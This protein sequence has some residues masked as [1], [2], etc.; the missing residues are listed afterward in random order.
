[1]VDGLGGAPD[2][3]AWGH[4]PAGWERGPADVDIW[5]ADVERHALAIGRLE[6]LLADAEWERVARYH[7]DRDRRRF[8]VVRGLLRALLGRYLGQPP[9]SLRIHYGPH[10][11][12]ELAPTS[13]TI[14]PLFDPRDAPRFDL[15]FNVSHSHGRALFAFARGHE[16]GV[17]LEFRRALA[18]AGAIA[19][20]YFAAGERAALEALPPEARAEA[21]FTCWAR[22]EAYIKGTG[23]GMITLLRTFEV[24]LAPGAPAALLAVPADPSAVGQWSLYD[25]PPIPGYA[26]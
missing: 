18:D 1:M 23:G 22:K 8:V 26:A 19:R 21:F 20:R 6:A 9:R 17:D 11:K 13:A 4:P 7:H 25:P 15:R 10:G 14:G 5:L 24:S 12:P 3:G 16:V 2:V